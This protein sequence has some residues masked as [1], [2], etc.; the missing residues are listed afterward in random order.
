MHVE[1]MGRLAHVGAYVV[2]VDVVGR[3]F[4]QHATGGAEQSPGGAQHQHDH[5][6]RGDGV[7]PRKPGGEDDDAGDDGGDEAV[8]AIERN[9]AEVDVAPRSIRQGGIFA[10]LA[11]DAFAR[12]A[13]KAGADKQTAELAA[14]LRHKK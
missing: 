14:G 5:D 2:E 13:R 3:G 9:R 4:E 6:Q 12:I 7:G 8:R 1:H 11:P 10:N